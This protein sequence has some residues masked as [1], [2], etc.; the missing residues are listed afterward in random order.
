[1]L[2]ATRKALR[3][4]VNHGDEDAA[5]AEVAAAERVIEAA[6]QIQVVSPWDLEGHNL[7]AALRDLAALTEQACICGEINARHCPVHGNPA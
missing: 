4:T 3:Y 5:L 7:L 1:M 6:A 2:D